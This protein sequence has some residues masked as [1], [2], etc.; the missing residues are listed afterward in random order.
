MAQTQRFLSVL[1]WIIRF[2][3]FYST[4]PFFDPEGFERRFPDLPGIGRK[5]LWNIGVGDK[6][7]LD[8]SASGFCRC[9]LFLQEALCHCY[10]LLTPD[11][12]WDSLVQVG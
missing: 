5:Y 3:W 4:S 8:E 9:Y 11:N 12:E 2:G 10:V 6:L 7:R 1:S